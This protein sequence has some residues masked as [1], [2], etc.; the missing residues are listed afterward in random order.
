MTINLKNFKFIQVD[1]REEINSKNWN[2]PDYRQA[3][4]TLKYRPDIILFESPCNGKTPDT[5]YNRY[6]CDS[7]PIR[8]VRE[9]QKFLKRAAKAPGFGDAE[10]DVLL[11]DNIIKLWNGGHNVL[12]Y[13]IDSPDDLRR[14]FFEV[15][16]YMYPCALK[17]WLW[18][19]RIYLRE[20]YMAK[21]FKWVIDQNKNRGNLVVAVFAQS[22]HWEHVKFLLANPTKKQIWEYYF[23]R[24]KEINPGNI[25]EKIKKENKIFYKYWKKCADF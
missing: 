7:K 6:D 20:K 15:W 10:S 18:W 12:I 9:H 5:V 21:N 22:F 23:G 25:A 11:W 1:V 8:L 2:G 3:E 16:K 14:S 19:V 17:N 13:N 4:A 24:F